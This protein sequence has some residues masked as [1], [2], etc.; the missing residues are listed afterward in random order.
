MA[1]RNIPNFSPVTNSPLKQ[2]LF[3]ATLEIHTWDR[4]TETS[5]YFKP[6]SNARRKRF[7][8]PYQH[9]KGKGEFLQPRAAG[10]CSRSLYEMNW[11]FQRGF[12]TLNGHS[13]RLYFLLLPLQSNRHSK[14]LKRLSQESSSL[15]QTSQMSSQYPLIRRQTWPQINTNSPTKIKHRKFQYCFLLKT[16]QGILSSLRNALLVYSS[17]FTVAKCSERT[18]IK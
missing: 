14:I 1:V 12:P 9:W 3:T 6:I 7:E 10:N 15:L 18:E 16:Q 17:N 4:I 2:R 5:N 8:D 13:P 11:I